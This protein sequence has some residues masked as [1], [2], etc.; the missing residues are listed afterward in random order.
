M[1]QKSIIFG[2]QKAILKKYKLNKR[3]YEYS[4]MTMKLNSNNSKFHNCVIKISQKMY[5]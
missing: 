1:H 5:H 2:H 3:M 4:Q